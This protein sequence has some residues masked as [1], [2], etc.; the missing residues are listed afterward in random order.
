MGH[1]EE[2]SAARLPGRGVFDLWV[3]RA[4]REGVG[5]YASDAR[6][7]T[8]SRPL[9]LASGIHRNGDDMWAR[10]DFDEGRLPFEIVLP[11]IFAGSEVA[12]YAPSRPD[13][14]ASDVRSFGG[15]VGGKWI[16]EMSRA[17]RTEHEDDIPFD[18]GRKYAFIVNLFQGK[19]LYGSS[20]S[21]VLTLHW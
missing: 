9:H 15:W 17:L 7:V 11:S 1:G 5:S 8:Y 14:S 18:R 20:A 16:V 13:G 2:G 3:W 19:D 4:G 6:L 21:G 10:L 12:S